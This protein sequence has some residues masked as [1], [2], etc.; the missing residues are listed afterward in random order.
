MK[1][2]EN[3]KANPSP[4]AKNGRVV[5]FKS[6]EIKDLAGRVEK[7]DVSQLFGN[8]LYKSTGD[9]G[10]FEVARKMYQEGTVEV[11]KP[12]Q[13]QLIRSLDDPRCMFTTILKTRLKE[14]IAGN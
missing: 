5:N 8:F 3:K 6:V 4:P 7:V 14:L 12:I 10:V 13:E 2:V 1:K 9:L 11:T